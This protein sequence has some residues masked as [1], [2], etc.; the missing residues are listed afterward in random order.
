MMHHVMSPA[1][2]QKLARKQSK[3][4]DTE[5]GKDWQIIAE[6][7]D[8]IFFVV[9]IVTIALTTL[10]MFYPIIFL[11]KTLNHNDTSLGP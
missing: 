10:L 8:R 11:Q 1:Q 3:D 9:Y 2:A 7:M 4:K 6:V 5:Y